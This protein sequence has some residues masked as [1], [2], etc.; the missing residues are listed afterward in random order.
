ME[1]SRDGRN[2]P[3]QGQEG[4]KGR[5]G[6]NDRLVTVKFKHL[7]EHE[8]ANFKASLDE[9]LQAIWERAYGELEIARGERDVLQAPGKHDNPTNLMPHLGLTLSQAQQQDL[10]DRDFEIAS[11]TGGA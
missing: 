8:R 11:E 2:D 9:T 5:R 1:L 3:A 4:E 7:A 6:D 10:C